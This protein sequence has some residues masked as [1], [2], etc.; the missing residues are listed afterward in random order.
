MKASHP[1]KS[2]AEEKL[3]WFGLTLTYPF[4]AFGGLY[5]MGSVIG[6][7]IFSIVMLRW[8]IN[9][10]ETASKVP[11]LVWLW[12]VGCLFLL[13]ALVIGH[14]N[15]DLGLS[16]LIK[17]SIGWAK[18]WALMPLFLFLGAFANIKPSVIVRAICVISYH[19]IFF[20]A[21]SLVLYIAG[22]HGD[23]FVSPLK[24]IGGP[25]ETFFTVSFYGLNPETG[26]GR[27][28]F[29]T[30]WA[31]A[32]GFMACIFLIFSFQE[33]DKFWRKAGI[34]GSFV[35]CLLSQSRAGWVIYLGLIPLCVFS[36]YF[37]NPLLFIIFGLSIPLLILVGE[38]IFHWLMS[39][40][41]DIKAARPGS[42]RVR[43]T[44]ENIALQRWQS[45]A[46]IWGHGIVER[47]PKIV[48]R[49][50]IGSHHTW[51][52]L[53]FVKGIVGLFALAIP[54]AITFVYLLINS[55]KSQVCYTALLMCIVLISYSFFENLEILSF[56]YW[57]AL[58]WIGISLNPLKSGEKNA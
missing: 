44:L 50:P 2:C 1:H 11:V 43:N 20:A 53:L 36:K 17:S 54:L 4:F 39:S 15:W 26:A 33:S 57:P 31:P 18:G 55:F 48:E 35:M 23:L 41:E 45:E 30:P 51:Y 47:G 12:I 21:I 37:K 42:T 8:Y 14:M 27:W 52:G 7:M 40:Y 29:F 19:S 5:V 13:L 56:L 10:K 32:A 25:G 3:V 38:P 22:V 9:G 16:K 34:L 46:P 6:W 28:R 58:L 49:M 24:V